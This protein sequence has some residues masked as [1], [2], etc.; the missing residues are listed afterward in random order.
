MIRVN[1]IDYPFPAIEINQLSV[2]GDAPTGG[3][4]GTAPL[5][6]ETLDFGGFFS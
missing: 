4:E 3:P 2:D 5:V 6:P 1:P